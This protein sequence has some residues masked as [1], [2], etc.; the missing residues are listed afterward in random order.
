MTPERIKQARQLTE[1]IN[2][3][4]DCYQLCQLWGSCPDGDVAPD[5]LLAWL[6]SNPHM[7]EIAVSINKLDK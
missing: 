4:T 6:I 5:V 3:F 2:N 1:E 7:A